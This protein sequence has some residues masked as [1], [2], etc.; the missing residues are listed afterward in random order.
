MAN[1]LMLNT[2][3]LLD[4]L[5]SRGG[6][7][8]MEHPADPDVH[9]LPSIWATDVMLGSQERRS[10]VCR[11]F[12]QCALGGPCRK[13]TTLTGNLAGLAGEG[14]F[15]PGVSA[16]HTLM[17]AQ[18]V[19]QP[20]VAF[21][22]NDSRFIFRAFATFWHLV[23]WT[24]SCACSQTAQDHLDGAGRTSRFREFPTG[25]WNPLRLRLRV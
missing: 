23:S 16:T 7:C 4:A 21:C 14:P 20:Q 12:D 9:P 8:G 5:A 15:C 11:T 13:P 17:S 3:A 19:E 1:V 22:P 10:F 25:R 18:W 2:L 24:L 6:A